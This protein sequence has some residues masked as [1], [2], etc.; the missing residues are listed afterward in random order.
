VPI[1]LMGIPPAL[2]TAQLADLLG[3][4]KQT[5]TMWVRR[6]KIKAARNERG[7]YEFARDD[8][9]ESI[10]PDRR[11]C[12]YRLLHPRDGARALGILPVTLSRWAKQGVVTQVRIGWQ[13]VYV[14][15]ELR[16]IAHIPRRRGGPASQFL[17]WETADL[18]DVADEEI[19][20]LIRVKELAVCAGDDPETYRISARELRCYLKAKF[21]E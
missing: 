21:W 7:H 5:V 19:L 15:E 17:V 11:T 4:H 12:N 1:R 18:L 10:P 3:M 13:C 2:S 9:L 16:A 14:A 20:R 6:G 8:L